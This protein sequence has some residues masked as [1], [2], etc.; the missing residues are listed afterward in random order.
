MLVKSKDLSADRAAPGLYEQ[1]KCVGWIRLIG[2]CLS[3]QG[4]CKQNPQRGLACGTLA[5]FGPRDLAWFGSAPCYIAH[6]AALLS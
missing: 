2:E 1:C 4:L 6:H 5:S 3:S